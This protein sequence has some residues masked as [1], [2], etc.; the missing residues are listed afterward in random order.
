MARI[1]VIF[2]NGDEGWL[3]EMGNSMY[4]Y[5]G[6]NPTAGTLLASDAGKLRVADDSGAD[7]SLV[8]RAIDRGYQVVGSQQT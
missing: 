5:R 6:D 4:A 1:R 7:G 3:E 2:D 8:L